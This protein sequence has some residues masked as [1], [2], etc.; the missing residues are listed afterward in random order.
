MIMHQLKTE[1]EIM[2]GWQGDISKPLIS[3][4]CIT[5]NHEKYIE[6]CLNGFLI[7]ETN[8]PF[9]ILVDD[10]FSQDNTAAIIREYQNK[11]PNIIK[12]NLRISNIGPMG[13]FT[14]NLKRATGEYIAVCEGDDY[15][16]DPQKLK[17]QITEMRKY[18]EIDMSFHPA[19]TVLNNKIHRITAQHSKEDRIYNTSE[20]IIGDGDFC[21]TASLMF[22][23]EILDKL[24]DW[25]FTIAPV[26]DYYLQI[27]GSI[28]GGLLYINKL[29]SAYRTHDDNW[30][31]TQ[32]NY[33][34]RLNFLIKNFNTTH[35]LNQSLALKFESQIECI[36]RKYIFNICLN[37]IIPPYERRIYFRKYSSLLST[38]QKIK[39]Y[40][41]YYTDFQYQIVK[42]LKDLK[43]KVHTR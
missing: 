25:Y 33:K 30:S 3:I 27:F 34:D 8:F 40:A 16:T 9:E 41:V 22:K 13:N 20:V 17:I 14:Q 42:C 21:P 43:V 12:P 4:C 1:L 15:W 7:Q 6:E 31:A 29:M 5:Y 19:Y 24:P 2:S 35:L 11:Y 37:K 38:F 18:P 10:D 26:G 39:F 28:S 23:K 32:K 36:Q